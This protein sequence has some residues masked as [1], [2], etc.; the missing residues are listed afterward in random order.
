[1]GLT[2]RQNK[3]VLR[4]D[5]IL[6]SGATVRS[7]NRHDI[8]RKTDVSPTFRLLGVNLTGDQSAG[9]NGADTKGDTMLRGMAACFCMTVLTGYA[10]GAGPA[11]LFTERVADFGTTAKGSVL[12]HYFR[13]TN[14]T[15]KT[16]VLG[17][18]RVSCGC[19]TATLSKSTVAPGETAAVVAY[20][21][22]RRIPT[23]NVTKSVL[24]YVPFLSPVQEE[25]TLRV[26]TVARDDL[27]ISPDRLAFGTVKFHTGGTQTTRVTFLGDPEW[28]I[29]EA[30]SSGAYVRVDYREESRRGQVVTYVVTA[31]LDQACPVGNWVS[32]VILKTSNPAV[33][34]LRIPVTVQVVPSLS[35]NPDAVALGDVPVGVAVERKLLLE[36]PAPFRI[37]DIKGTDDELLVTVD[38]SVSSRSHEV[39]VAAS[40]KTAGGLRR[41]VEIVTDYPDA[42]AVVIL[43]T[44]R[45]VEVKK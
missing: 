6:T 20:M 10:V 44:G 42:P 37:L 16:L 30:H 40:P 35:V 31:T 32:E 18:P 29:L 45:V 3:S 11:D 7:G 36:A 17:T 21:D 19:V 43:V 9:R 39:M 12:V 41:A 22:T 1:M 15:D 23:A 8:R 27:L 33:A 13:F 4:V 34:R 5:V 2:V 28:K 26:Q 24:I 38:R 14:T 25:V